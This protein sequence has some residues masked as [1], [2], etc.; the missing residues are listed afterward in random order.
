MIHLSV[1]LNK[2]ALIRNSRGNNLPDLLQVAQDCVRFGADG[3]T[4][5][6]RP[7][8]RHARQQDIYDLKDILT[9]ELNVEGFPS[10]P[11]LRLI[12]TA[13]P[14]QCTLVPDA[15]DALTSNSGWDTQ[16]HSHF[17]L[18]AVQRIEA[19]G[20]RSSIFVEPD[21]DRIEGARSI[22]ATRIELYTEPYAAAYAR[23]RH[24]AVEDYARAAAYAHELGLGINAGHDLNL[25]NLTFFA[26]EV[27]YLDEVS[28]GHALISDALYLG[29]AETIA[30]Y[31]ACL[32]P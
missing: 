26:Q 10:E 6:P 2:V 4:L 31:Q 22:G 29:L 18:E 17:L 16:R 8:E 21:L 32:K 14:A 25:H 20:V 7:D 15:P 11:F 30:R 23:G 28:I 27:P 1:N 13:R 24:A 12:E 9:V 3:I 5:H 19:A